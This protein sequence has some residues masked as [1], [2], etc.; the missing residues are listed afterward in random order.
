ML[1]QFA[2]FVF[3]QHKFRKTAVEA[4]EESGERKDARCTQVLQ[5]AWWMDVDFGREPFLLL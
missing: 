4:D 5:T 2:A 1:R 3:L